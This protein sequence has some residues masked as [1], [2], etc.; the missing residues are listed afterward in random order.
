MLERIAP[1]IR[2]I[3]ETSSEVTVLCTSRQPLGIFRAEVV[4]SV[5][6]LAV[7][8]SDDPTTFEGSPAVRLFVDRASAARHHLQ[9]PP[10]ELELV[11]EIC[12]RLDGIP[13][14]LELAA[15]RASSM[16]LQDILENLHP[17]SPI[18]AMPTPDHP[19]HRTL[20]RG[21]NGPTTS[22]PRRGVPSSNDCPCS[23][24]PGLPG[25]RVKS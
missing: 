25:R 15:A 3:A 8:S 19:R 21:S 7:P 4:F 1:L 5:E 14:A 16:S 20:Y 11:A 17:R 13:L 12:R 9:L 22:S 18:L 2:D 6:P 24:D 10:E 23:R